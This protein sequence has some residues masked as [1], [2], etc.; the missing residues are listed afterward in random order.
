MSVPTMPVAESGTLSPLQQELALIQPKAGGQIVLK[1]NFM[2]MAT[3]GVSLLTII[4]DLSYFYRPAL[5]FQ[6]C[7][8]WHSS[9]S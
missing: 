1:D 9:T 5:L 3:H 4:V 7:S 6:T 8:T 2:S